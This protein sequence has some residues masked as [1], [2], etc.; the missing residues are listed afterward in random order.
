MIF[1]KEKFWKPFEQYLKATIQAEI[2]KEVKHILNGCGFDNNLSI[3]SLSVADIEKIE[4]YVNS[5]PHFLKKLKSYKTNEKFE[6]KPGH[7]SVILNLPRHYQHYIS[8]RTSENAQQNTNSSNQS[9]D[10]RLD[11]GLETLTTTST[12]TATQQKQNKGLKKSVD[13]LKKQ[14][15][16]KLNCYM[17][18]F[19]FEVEFNVNEI[20]DFCKNNEYYKCR[21]KCCF[22]SKTIVCNYLSH[23]VVSNL[24]AHLK[25][26]IKDIDNSSETPN[27]VLSSCISNVV[28]PSTKTSGEIF[29]TVKDVEPSVERHILNGQN[30][31]DKCTIHR[32]DSSTDQE[33]QN[34]LN[35]T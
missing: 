25:K 21:M 27:N 2:P 17:K 5:N 34:I 23:W 32:V 31:T 18:R 1:L 29:P 22:C 33:L 24:E 13:E 35:K 28:V 26:H 19:N 20:S 16:N 10:Q 6:V 3:L 9:L 4:T 30:I 15:T 11:L 14:L 12:L 7:R 8:D